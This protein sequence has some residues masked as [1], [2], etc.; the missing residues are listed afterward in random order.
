[1]VLFFYF[2]SEEDKN[3]KKVN[4]YIYTD[5]TLHSESEYNSPIKGQEV[6]L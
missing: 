3:F 6:N 1:M 4:M 2:N 5:E